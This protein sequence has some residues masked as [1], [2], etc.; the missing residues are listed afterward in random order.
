MKLSWQQITLPALA[1]G[2]LA[3]GA[4]GHAN[5]QA[6]IKIDG[7]STV[8]PISE[9]YAEEFQI[10]KRGKVRVTVGVSGTGG[11]F[12][13][14][15]RGETDMANAS[16]PILVAE[17]EACRKAGIK[18]MEVPV[19]FDALTV[20]INPANTWAKSMTVAELRKMWEPAAQ[21]RIMTWNQVNPKFPKEKL[22]LFGP[23]ADSG[24]F[25]YFTEAVNGKSK[26]SRGDFT[27]S[28]DDNTLV[29]GVENNKTAL[30]Y[31]GYAYYAA[32]KDKLKAVAIDNGK[33]PV[34]PSLENVTNGT[35]N[36][37]SRPLFI[38]VRDTSAKRPEVR[39]FVQFMLTNGDLVAEVGY[40]PLPKS[41]YNLAWKHFQ[42]GK[43]G[44]VFGGHPQVG[45]TIEQLQALEGK[46]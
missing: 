1:L 25:D 17:M 28:E 13:K 34:S 5:A 4:P 29:Q 12:K 2:L 7:S 24:T 39:E 8:F 41:A 6:A 33:G 27:A 42:D 19:A 11:G 18:Y 40:L 21:G 3:I 36:P 31:F 32:H 46:L 22:M 26:A 20:V 15:C 16:R 45:I 38:Y 30:G 10:Q 14:F 23:G 9:A 35:Y 44:T 37:L 43:L